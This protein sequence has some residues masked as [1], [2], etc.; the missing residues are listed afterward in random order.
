MLHHHSTLHDLL[1][2]QLKDVYSGESQLACEALP[3]MV[4]RSTNRGLAELLTDHLSET[5]G[6]IKRLDRVA[7]L[8]G[9]NLSK[10]H[11]TAMQGL[12][13][14]AFAWMDQEAGPEILDAGIVANAQRIE[15]YEI[16]AYAA[17]CSFSRLLGE[18]A[19][20]DLLR[21]SI[22]EKQAFSDALSAAAET[23]FKAAADAR[24]RVKPM[25]PITLSDRLE[26]LANTGQNFV[27]VTLRHS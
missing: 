4:Y 8:L 7:G 9:V 14:A 18:T 3:K 26:R 15:Q 20:V 25:D 11:S 23:L 2:V 17:T 24:V 10:S 16:G 12:L 1:L 13:T 5:K 6:Q 21:E 22:R 27:E 19:S